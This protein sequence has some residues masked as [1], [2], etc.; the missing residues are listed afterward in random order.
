[1]APLWRGEGRAVWEDGR[2]VSRILLLLVWMG[3]ASGLAFLALFLDKQAAARGRSRIPERTLHI[4]EL[5]GGW[6]GT[7]LAM[8]LVRHKSR[9]LSYRLVTAGILLLHA[10]L[11]YAAWKSGW[12]EG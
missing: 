11:G 1:M 2:T 9:K 8:R 12:M 6:P 10:A 3:V 5:L 7:L 4:L